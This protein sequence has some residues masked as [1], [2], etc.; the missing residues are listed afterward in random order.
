MDK[1]FKCP[2]ELIKYFSPDINNL[3]IDW[4][5]FESILIS[6]GYWADLHDLDANS[7][8]YG[9]YYQDN[10]ILKAYNYD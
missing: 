10:L 1:T 5:K 4:D 3:R 2:Y 6:N 8:E 7:S 9:V